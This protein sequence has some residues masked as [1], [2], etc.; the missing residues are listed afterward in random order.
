M[1]ISFSFNLVIYHLCASSSASNP[2]SSVKLIQRNEFLCRTFSLPPLV[3][4]LHLATPRSVLC[5]FYFHLLILEGQE[6]LFWC[7]IFARQFW[8]S[9]FARQFRVTEM[10]NKIPRRK[11]RFLGMEEGT[12]FVFFPQLRKEIWKTHA[13]NLDHDPIFYLFS[14]FFMEVISSFLKISRSS[15]SILSGFEDVAAGSSVCVCVW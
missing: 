11:L 15:H 14:R 4:L 9:I 1:F 10:L 5:L 8:C 13:R 12:V 6:I 3:R 7:S 2:A